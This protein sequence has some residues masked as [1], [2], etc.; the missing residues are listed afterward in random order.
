M[1][2]CAA[3]MSTTATASPD[4]V[5]WLR[6]TRGMLEKLSAPRATNRPPSCMSWMNTGARRRDDVGI[7]GEALR[8]V[9]LPDA[10]PAEG[11]QDVVGVLPSPEASWDLLAEV[12][13]ARSGVLPRLAHADRCHRLVCSKTPQKASKSAISRE[14]NL[15]RAGYAG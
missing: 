12:E 2:R 10:A 4:T 15:L 8:P 11:L 3:A 5:I 7:H 14:I 9:E 1:V 13:D 6:A